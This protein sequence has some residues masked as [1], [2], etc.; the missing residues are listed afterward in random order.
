MNAT[1]TL[2]EVETLSK[3]VQADH[4]TPE[5]MGQYKEA[6]EQSES[7]YLVLD[8]FL[9]SKYLKPLRQLALHEGQMETV[10]KTFDIPNFIPKEEFDKNDQENQFIIEEVYRG[11]KDNFKMGKPALT[12]L[13]LR[14]FVRSHEFHRFLNL[15]MNCAIN[16][17]G[18]NIHLKALKYGHFLKAHSD[19][20][21]NR[22]AC[23][24]IYLHEDWQ[25]EYKGRFIM[26]GLHGEHEY[27]DP[28]TNRILMFDPNVGTTH[29]VEP[30][31]DPGKNWTRINYTI[32]F[33]N[34]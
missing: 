20:F 33:Y 30:I 34:K 14:K 12:D 3:W 9:C 16:E 26:N 11:P 18:S 25:E 21:P 22:V 24:V 8:N 10:Y 23:M 19:R 5:K 29:E 27:V 4:L 2:S 28:I 31:A 7:K 6:F 32:W 17:T 13:L 1:L 15:I